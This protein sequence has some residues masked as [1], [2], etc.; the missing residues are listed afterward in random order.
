MV[1]ISMISANAQNRDKRIR[2]RVDSALTAR[3]Y[4]ISYDTNYVVRPEG[5]LTLKF[6]LNQ[7]GNSIH[8]K[9]TV[10]DIYSK[11]DLQTS[12]KTTISLAA[13][14][15]GISVG[16]TINPA[17]I[18]GVYKDYE[19]NLNYYSSR[20]SVDASYQRASTLSGNIERG[21]MQ[22]MESGDVGM[23]VLNLQPS[24]FLL[25]GSLQPV[26][27]P[28]PLGRLVARRVKLPR[29]QHR[30]HRRTEREK[31]QCP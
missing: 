25:S 16:F 1:L 10:N 28:T 7:T 17:K 22:R 11:A 15:R 14:Y 12:H 5:R 30:D 24:P 26:V 9:G 2:A 21:G 3:Y 6:R 8:A 4:N 18:R 19:F 29:G 23:K 20:I 13:I 27:H 31:P